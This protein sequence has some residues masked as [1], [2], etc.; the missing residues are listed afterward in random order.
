VGRAGN[1]NS[2][3]RSPAGMTSKKSKCKNNC[4]GNNKKCKCND[5]RSPAGMTSKKNKCKDKCSGNNKKCKCND[6]SG[7]PAG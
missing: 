5:N 2:K 4:I 3:S 1:G 7:F 6:K